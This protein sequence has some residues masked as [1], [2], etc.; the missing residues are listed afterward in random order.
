[1]EIIKLGALIVTV[2]FLV[3]SIPT[4]SK[5]ISIIIIFSCCTVV[6]LYILKMIVPGIEYIKKIAENIAFDNIDVVF[7]AV[8]IGFITQF[9]ADIAADCNNRTLANQM[10]F[11]GR[12]CVLM[13]AMPLF[14]QILDIIERLTNL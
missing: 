4:F 12:V 6:L 8:G 1:M 14:I 10:I 13:L 5:E 9:V 3:N 7:K 2:L 11:A